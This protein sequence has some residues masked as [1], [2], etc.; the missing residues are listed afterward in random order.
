MAAALEP[1]AD[2]DCLQVIVTARNIGQSRSAG[3]QAGRS[4]QG[5]VRTDDGNRSGALG[6][7]S[8]ESGVQANLFLAGGEIRSAGE[9][10]RD[11]AVDVDESRVRPERIATPVEG[12]A[13]AG[14][15]ADDCD[16]SVGSARTRSR[17]HREPPPRPRLALTPTV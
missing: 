8:A 3:R 1:V 5:S 11:D 16:A 17:D 15:S 6:T 14:D 2:R 10:K 7:S 13:A 9:A 12:A 4:N